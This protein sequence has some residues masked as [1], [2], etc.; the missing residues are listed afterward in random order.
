MILNNNNVMILKKRILLSPLFL[1]ILVLQFS[2]KT[3]G[4]EV[5]YPFWGKYEKIPNGEAKPDLWKTKDHI[6]EGWDWSL[7][8][9]TKASPKGLIGMA[10]VLNSKSLHSLSQ[11]PKVNF[12][13]NPILPLYDL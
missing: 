4:Q 8:P 2:L 7:P 12:E 1:F 9:N 13:C 3:T 11:L 10:R 5:E 6:K